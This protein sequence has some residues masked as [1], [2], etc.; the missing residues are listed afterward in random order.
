MAAKAQGGREAATTY[1]VIENYPGHALVLVKPLT[2]RTHQIR[3]HLKS[4]GTPVLCDATYSK[5]NRIYASDLLKRKKIKGEKPLLT[6]QALHA[7]RLAFTHP[8][9]GKKLVFEAC[10]PSDMQDVIDVLDSSMI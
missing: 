7:C 8:N 1:S 4:I 10:L 6:R 2:G 9:S 5:T 3:V